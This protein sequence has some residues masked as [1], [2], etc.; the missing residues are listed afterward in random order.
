MR[1]LARMLLRERSQSER[2]TCL[3][4]TIRDLGGGKMQREERPGAG[5]GGEGRVGGAQTQQ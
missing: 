2:V 4:P 5:G 1:N 3:I